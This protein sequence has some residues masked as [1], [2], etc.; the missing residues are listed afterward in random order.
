[1]R[2]VSQGFS[3]W[4]LFF[5]HRP[6]NHV[7]LSIFRIF[8]ISLYNA[9]DFTQEKKAP[10]QKNPETRVSLFVKRNCFLPRIGKSR[11]RIPGAPLVSMRNKKYWQ[12]RFSI[13]F[14][15]DEEDS[16]DEPSQKAGIAKKR[17]DTLIVSE[18]LATLYE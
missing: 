15:A 13:R 5:I 9:I 3:E 17:W 10:I 14:K 2:H 12:K 18:V 11:T 7:I 16:E 6:C 8:H 1:M 4:A